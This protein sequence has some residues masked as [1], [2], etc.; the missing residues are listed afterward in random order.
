MSAPGAGEAARELVRIARIVAA[1]G[2]A[3]SS[4]GNLSVRLPDGSLLVTPR[5][6]YKPDLTPEQL[7]VVDLE[8]RRLAGP[9]GLAPTSELPMH[10]AVYR[11]RPDVAAVLHAHP[12]HATALTIAGISLPID[13]LPEVAATLGE[14]PT[15]PYAPPGSEALALGLGRLARDH[16]AVLLSHHGSVTMGRTLVDAL[17]ALERLEHA[18]LVTCLAR[19]LGGIVPLPPDEVARLRR[20]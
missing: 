14:V 18:A 6:V 20:R 19:G 10:A 3:R 7:V 5:G 8:G 16:D 11:E 12:P 9:E 15:A 2:L 1:Q 13:L 4:D 17:I